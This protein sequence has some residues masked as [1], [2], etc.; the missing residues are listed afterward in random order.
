M[1]S[2]S[3]AL[4]VLELPSAKV[5]LS[6]ITFES[7]YQLSLDAAVVV[8][9]NASSVSKAENVAL[10][11][12]VVNEVLGQMEEKAISLAAP[13]TSMKS[14]VEK[15]ENLKRLVD[16]VVPVVFSRLPHLNPSVLQTLAVVL[17]CLSVCKKASSG[18]EVAAVVSDVSAAPAVVAAPAV[19]VVA[20][21]A[22]PAAVVAAPAAVVEEK[23]L[24]PK[25]SAVKKL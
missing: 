21:V 17:N 13:E 12:S 24:S 18:E 10:L 2:K 1:N 22:A 8:M 23:I 7:V 19:A 25:N 4:K 6:A 9:K 16:E 20:V 3:L 11:V 5:D 15:C 14:I